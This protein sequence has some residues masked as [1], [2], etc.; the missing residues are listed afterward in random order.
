MRSHGGLNLHFPIANNIEHLSMGSLAL[1]LVFFAVKCLF[2]S[3]AH[4][5]I[6]LLPFYC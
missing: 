4:I 5:L 3:L 1:S 2:V 6:G